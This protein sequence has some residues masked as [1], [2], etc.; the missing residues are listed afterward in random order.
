MLLPTHVQRH[1]NF[2]VVLYQ[3]IQHL[4]QRIGPH[5]DQRQ[6]RQRSSSLLLLI[7]FVDAPRCRRVPRTVAARTQ[8]RRRPARL[9][10]RQEGRIEIVQAAGVQIGD[11]EVE[12]VTRR[13]TCLGRTGPGAAACVYCCCGRRCS[14][15]VVVDF[16][17]FATER[18][19]S[20]SLVVSHLLLRR[21]V[22]D[23]CPG[24]IKTALTCSSRPSRSA[25]GNAAR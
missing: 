19:M 10:R 17:P 21:A 1:G 15:L 23:Q 25:L 7:A 4:V 3:D 5:I 8:R 14:V 24:H 20:A 22:I 13:G 2:G 12:I 18:A 16:F 6:R 11:V 9:M